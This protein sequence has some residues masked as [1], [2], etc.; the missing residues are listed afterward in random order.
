MKKGA[1]V[2][3]ASRFGGPREREDNVQCTIAWIAKQ[4]AQLKGY[5][6][7]GAYHGAVAGFDHMY[8]VPNDTIT[9]DEASL[10]GIRNPDD[11]FGGV[12]PHVFMKSKSLTHELVDGLADRPEGWPKHLTKQLGRV[13]LPGHS[14]FSTHDAQRAARRLLSGGG[15]I[16]AKNPLGSGGGG[17][18]VIRTTDELDNFLES[19]PEET[20]ATYGLVLELDLA[21]V[22]TMNIGRVIIDQAEVSYYGTQR[23]TPNNDGVLEYGGSHLVCVRGG[24]DA[25]EKLSMD[26]D[27]RA[28]IRQAKV[29]DTVMDGCSGFMASRRNYDVGIG[30]DATGHRRIGVFEQTWRWGAAST[31]ELVALGELERDPDTHVIEISCIKE[32]GEHRKAPV[33]AVIIYGANDPIAGPMI[34]YTLVTKMTRKAEFAQPAALSTGTDERG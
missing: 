3:Y 6:F 10:L 13:V 4:I 12:V 24:W 20:L 9:T 19:F 14:V 25:L 16:R 5:N 23:M 27:T 18:A 2:V 1:V 7:S 8:F 11:F 28:C 33:G 26:S 15:P 29:F 32:F 21:R 17:Q 31:A 34:R 22:T 30:F